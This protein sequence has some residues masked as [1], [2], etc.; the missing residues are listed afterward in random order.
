MGERNAGNFGLVIAYLIPGVTALWGTSFYSDTVRTWLSGT[1]PSPPTVGGFFYVTLGS[2]AA[3][4]TAS[5]V[6][7][8]VIDTIHHWTGVPHAACDFSR[9]RHNVAAVGLLIDI[10][11]R[12][13]QFYGNTL[14]AL[15]FAYASR[16][17]ALGLW[18]E[19]LTWDD[20]AF[21]LVACL[22]FVGSRDTLRKYNTRTDALFPE[23]SC[24]FPQ[25][26][27]WPNAENGRNNATPPPR[28]REVTNSDEGR[29]AAKFPD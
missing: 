25:K 6:R 3:G 16:K 2:I 20:L 8:T 7:W 27:A 28:G 22:F 14:V 24:R 12:Y 21:V 23:T 4:L 29:G 13:Y 19:F 10:H 17:T 1:S 5:T 11:Y 9:L 26:A 18:G 15:T